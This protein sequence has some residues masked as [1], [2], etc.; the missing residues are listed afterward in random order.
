MYGKIQVQ[1]NHMSNAQFLTQSNLWGNSIIQSY[2]LIQIKKGTNP[3]NSDL[4]HIP[5][6][7]LAFVWNMY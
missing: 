1:M 5:F 4:W 6:M 2:T 7:E 3:T